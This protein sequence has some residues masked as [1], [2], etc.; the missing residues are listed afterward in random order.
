[1]KWEM[2]KS[3]SRVQYYHLRVGS[4]RLAVTRE[5][6]GEERSTWWYWK[7]FYYG[8][9]DTSTGGVR[10]RESAPVFKTAAAAREAAVFELLGVQ[11]EALAEVAG[12]H[13]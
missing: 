11:A 9:D 13:R 8:P 6:F 12:D 2:R 3:G 1:M 10:L 4:Y 7:L 5:G